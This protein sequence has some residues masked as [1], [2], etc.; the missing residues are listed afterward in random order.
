MRKIKF[1]PAFLT[2]MFV[3]CLF[4]A[5]DWLN[6]LYTE[7]MIFSKDAALSLAFS[8]R[9]QGEEFN[10]VR[11]NCRR[12]LFEPAVML[13]RSSSREYER[14]VTNDFCLFK[15]NPGENVGVYQIKHTDDEYSVSIK[16]FSVG[17]HSEA[18]IINALYH[19]VGKAQK[20]N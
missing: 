17:S 19:I 6:R 5:I 4:M 11:V 10:L 2:V 15:L 1:N 12:N 9:F 16:G 13:Y 18:E 14:E 20:Y 7:S 8:H 3:I